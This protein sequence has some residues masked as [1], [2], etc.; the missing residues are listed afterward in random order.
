VSLGSGLLRLHSQSLLLVQGGRTHKW[1]PVWQT[2]G[3]PELACKLCQRSTR[4]PVPAGRPWVHTERL[5][6]AQPDHELCCSL[7]AFLGFIVRASS[8]P[9][10]P[11]WVNRMS[12]AAD[13]RVATVPPRK[14]PM[15]PELARMLMSERRPA[16]E[17][18]Y[19]RMMP[20]TGLKMLR[21][22]VYF[23]VS[24]NND[25]YGRRTLMRVIAWSSITSLRPRA[26][27]QYYKSPPL[28]Q[29]CKTDWQQISTS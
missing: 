27:V 18:L 9:R 4:N 25:E 10:L 24:H 23:H 3:R 28:C 14:H 1:G 15:F 12:A 17:L 8:L 29:V 26:L 6:V 7:Q 20:A 13:S 11:N 2:A 16:T 22:S 21:G 5:S 19:A